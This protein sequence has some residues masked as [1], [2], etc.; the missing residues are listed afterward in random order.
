MSKIKI[1]LDFYNNSLTTINAKQLDTFSRFVNVT[2]TD[3][4]RKFLLDKNR[5]SVYVRYLKSDNNIVWNHANVLDDGTVD[6]EITQQMTASYGRN[7]F[8][9][10][11]FGKN[12]ITVDD[13]KD[14]K[15]MEDLNTF[16]LSTMQCCINTYNTVVPFNQIES[17]SEYNGLLYATALAENMENYISDREFERQKAETERQFGE[18]GEEYRKA[19]EDTR[20][21]KEAERQTGEFGEEY[22]RNQELLRQQAE[23]K[24]Q[25]NISGEQYRISNE[26]TRQDI[27]NGWVST[28]NEKLDAIDEATTKANNASDRFEEIENFSGIIMKEEKGVADGIA[29]LDENGQVPINQLGNVHKIL[30]GYKTPTSDIG[31]DGDIYMMIIE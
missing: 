31:Q 4:G 30:Y 16:V 6:I 7:Y 29:T 2:C 20:Q 8:D 23:I 12:G 25:D 3:L 17:T 22:R 24:R 10:V 27:F 13:L 11:I 28:I 1:N 26:S 15:S 9:I 14:V 18:F 5:M 19:Q 21:Q